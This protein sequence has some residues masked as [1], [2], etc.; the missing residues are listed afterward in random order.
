MRKKIELHLV[1]GSARSGST[2][3]VRRIAEEYSALTLKSDLHYGSL[4]V[5]LLN[6]FKY[7]RNRNWRSDQEDFWKEIKYTDLVYTL[8][9]TESNFK[10]ITYRNYFHFLIEHIK[11]N[12]YMKNK[13]S[14]VM[15][16]D[17]E[18]C[19]DRKVLAF[20]YEE[21]IDFDIIF[22]H[23][24]RDFTSY[25]ISYYYMPNERKKSNKLAKLVWL[26]LGV[27]RYVSY[28]NNFRLLSDT[29]HSYK[30]ISFELATDYSISL[31]GDVT[32][33]Y[34][35]EKNGVLINS[36]DKSDVPYLAFWC[37]LFLLIKRSRFFNHMIMLA[38]TSQRGGNYSGFY[39]H[40]LFKNNPELLISQLQL[41]GNKKLAKCVEYSRL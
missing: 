15:K 29:P 27:V 31:K 41:S 9:I 13:N 8:G 17:P 1:C 26:F 3:L 39:R 22:W 35:T 14:F 18:V 34:T 11:R 16:L 25:F 19:L 30:N 36:S 10:S 24:E 2:N 6:N 40:Y 21:L 4:E 32:K 20:L 33:E 28:N 37:K 38:Y 7:F 12:M 23:V 5:D